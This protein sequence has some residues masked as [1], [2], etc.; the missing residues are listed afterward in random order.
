MKL[1][2][3]PLVVLVVF[4]LQ[5]CKER[6]Q[7][8]RPDDISG[9]FVDFNSTE[10]VKDQ[11]LKK[12][13]LFLSAYNELIRKAEIALNEGPFSVMDKKRIPPGGDMHD[14]LSMGPYWWPDPAKPDGL[15]Y[16]RRDGEVNPETRGEH[17]DTDTKNKMFNNLE[18]LAWA[19]Y[20][21]EENKY[22]GKAVELLET[23]FVNP[24]TRMNPNL[25]Y[26]QGIPGRTEGRGI[27]I[28]D[29]AGINKIITPVRIL[30]KYGKLTPETRDKL[31]SWFGQFLDW[32]LT[33]DHGK[34]E[35]D[36][37]NNHGTWYDVETAG[38]ALLLGKTDTA[39]M[40]LENLKQKRIATQIEPD[41]S[42]PFEIA[43]T[44]SLSYSSMNLRGFI[45]LA[46]MAQIVNVDLWDFKTPD[47]RG[48]R[49]ALDFLL[50]YATGEKK[51]EYHQITGLDDALDGLRLNYLIAASKTGDKR[52]REV[53]NLMPEQPGNLEILL[54]PD[55]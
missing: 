11:L 44:R 2:N 33:S 22:A 38:I 4:S 20:F 28:I 42:Q 47:G 13:E 23:W 14:Y 19:F 26:A 46:N 6:V 16:I 41:G 24:E 18:T 54:Y 12:D 7:F 1:S 50:P 30:E 17:V 29:F 8:S 34:D 25:N 53:I 49:T 9:I 3:I 45:H 43:R 40:I 36:E 31:Y 5:N 51:W 32:L 52:Y 35:A 55:L 10:K 48:I 15:P 39:G 27:G 21:S 37:H